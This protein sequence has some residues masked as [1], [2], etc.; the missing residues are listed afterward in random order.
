MLTLID[1]ISNLNYRNKFFIINKMVET[2]NA[3]Q[4]PAEMAAEAPAS[5]YRTYLEAHPEMTNELMKVLVQMYQD[6][7]KES[8]AAE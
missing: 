3:N 5:S 4:N 1:S 2:A 7:P 8:Q 6:P